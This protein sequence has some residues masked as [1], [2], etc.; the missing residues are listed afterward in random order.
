MYLILVSVLFM[1]TGT[2][3][4]ADEATPAP[5][6]FTGVPSRVAVNPLLWIESATGSPIANDVQSAVT[7]F[8]SGGFES[9]LGAAYFGDFYSG[10]WLAFDLEITQSEL[11]VLRI[12]N[13]LIDQLE[14][15][16]TRDG[17][18]VHRQ[19]GGTLQGGATY[20]LGFAT[21]DF[22]LHLDA[23]AYRV[24]LRVKGAEIFLPVS[25][26]GIDRYVH[27][28]TSRELLYAFFYTVMFA[29]IVGTVFSFLFVD[30][31]RLYYLYHLAFLFAYL[32]YQLS[33]DG[34]LNGL[35][36]PGNV[37]L[38]HR[39]HLFATA[40]ALIFLQQLIL[41][42]LCVRERGLR[43]YTFLQAAMAIP[44]F[45]MAGL[46]VV[47]DGYLPLFESIARAALILLLF[48]Q[49]GVTF[50]GL[51]SRDR[52]DRIFSVGWQFAIVGIL[53]AALKAKGVFPYPN[54][55]LFAFV[56]V[57]T[58]G[59]FFLVAVTVRLAELSRS[60]RLTEV[61]LK[62]ANQR[63][64]QSRGRPHFLLNTFGLIQHLVRT[65]PED[66][67]SAFRLLID[68]FRFF[69]DRATSPLVPLQEELSFTFNYL[70]IMKLRHG[71]ELPVI[72]DVGAF[73]PH[74]LIPP[75]SLQP[76]VENAVKHRAGAGP[77][78][79]ALSAAD[80]VCDW[81]VR[82]P[83]SGDDRPEFPG[84]ETHRN[85]LSRLQYYVPDARLSLRIQDG[86]FHAS[87]RWSVP[88]TAT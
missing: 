9:A 70:K 60:K 19:A 59:V 79:I 85:I 71:G 58:E 49:L 40:L 39:F 88:E 87:L 83:V 68:D 10:R 30:R 57:L 66:A 32:L 20:H 41:S 73:P 34:I 44:V 53:I 2:L 13:Y 51:F 15:Y 18:V 36:W 52:A 3:A 11:L 65:A 37:Y 46:L 33:R 23:G 28:V 61:A 56:G 62:E 64:L 1:L 63:I 50:T 31:H 17:I 81:T 22:P 74:A 14:L 72:Q 67:E 77:L 12:E 29:V 27:D 25:L 69:T 5:V 7:G 55:T 43:R 82:N 80:G 48:I 54:F 75:L 76:L 86:M 45:A 8:E 78:R 42:F 84:G 38:T 16:V 47:G 21:H 35:L 6:Q 26:A 24:F 4:G